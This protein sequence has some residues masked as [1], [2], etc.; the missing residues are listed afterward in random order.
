MKKLNLK[1]ILVLLAHALIVWMFCDAVMVIGMAVVGTEA[2]LI[3]HLIAAPIFTILVSGFYFR[4]FNYTTPFQTALVL[5]SFIIIMDVF[6]VAMI[7]NKS[8]DMF[9]SIIGTW[10]PFVLIFAAVYLTGVICIKHKIQAGR[11]MDKTM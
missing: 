8:F 3:I 6:L 7:I 1:R 4:K 10:L 11:D 2:A 5:I 9:T